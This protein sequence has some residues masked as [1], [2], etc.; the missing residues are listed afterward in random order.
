MP[1]FPRQLVFVVTVLLGIPGMSAAQTES[2]WGVSGSFTPMWKSIESLR[3]FYISG[4]GELEGKEL[5]IG[6]VRGST[7]GGD[8]GVSFV[9]KPFKDGVTIVDPGEDTGLVCSGTFCT[10]AL[11]PEPRRCAMCG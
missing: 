2:H 4:E 6:F 1:V 3:D 7:A 9:H 10:P 5:T 11:I 8:W